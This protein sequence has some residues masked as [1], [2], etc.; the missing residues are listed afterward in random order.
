M[1]NG[2]AERLDEPAFSAGHAHKRSRPKTSMQPLT[3]YQTIH[4]TRTISGASVEAAMAA[5][6]GLTPTKPWPYAPSAIVIA[7]S[8]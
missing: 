1:R 2:T 6:T 3:K 5:R 4:S 8:Q 7:A